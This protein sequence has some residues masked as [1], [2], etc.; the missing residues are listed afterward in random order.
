MG[1]AG[2]SAPGGAG[3]TVPTDAAAPAVD[4]PPGSEPPEGSDP[5]PIDLSKFRHS[6]PL[7]LDTTP[8]GAG[9]A[10]D[11]AA[12]PVAIKLS[13]ANFDFSQAKP[14]GEDVRF[15]SADGKP[16]PYA[17]EL[18]DAAKKEAALWVSVDIKGGSTQTINLH[19]GNA[20]AASAA[21]SKAVFSKAA[22]FIGVYHLNQDGNTVEGG[23]KDASW[24]EAHGV[25]VKLAP[26]SLEPARVGYGTRFDNPKGGASGE[27]RW[28][29]VAGPKVTTDFG[30]AEHPISVSAW[31]FANT[32]DGYYQ[33]IFS[34]GDGTYSLQKDYM[35][36]TEVCMSPL[37]GTNH[38][39]AITSPPPTKVWTHYMIMRKNGPYA[40]NSLVLYINGKRAAGI[41]A[42]GKQIDLP[43]GIANQSLRGRERNQKGFN[44]IIDEVRVMPVERGEDWAKLEYE[45]QREGSKFVTFGETK[46]AL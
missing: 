33:T 36:R 31:A 22:G 38:M 1:G 26:G 25:G 29:E 30:S 15:S 7:K 43:F 39:C 44:G 42:G 18:W 35:G 11:I 13:A 21:N 17:I 19:W 3:G 8:A 6:K 45:S 12:Y 41:S 37:T 46:T 32:W 34:K 4:A 9:V 10:S 40:S 24:N 16:L 5:G 14:A 23:Y 28:V 27:I 20:D 2:G